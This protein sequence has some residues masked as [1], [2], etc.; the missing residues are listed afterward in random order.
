MPADTDQRLKNGRYYGIVP[1]GQV[2]DDSRLNRPGFTEEI[3]FQ[4]LCGFIKS[5]Q[6]FKEGLLGFCG[7][8]VFDGA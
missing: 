6:V 1:T 7:S 2:P 4:R 5:V 8:F 3:L